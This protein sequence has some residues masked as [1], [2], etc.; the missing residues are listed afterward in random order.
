[1]TNRNYSS[2][3]FRKNTDDAVIVNEHKT[4][5]RE[6]NACKVVFKDKHGKEQEVE[7]SRLIQVFLNNIWENKKSVK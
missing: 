6:A 1:M 3:D 4:V 7:V 5:I 2:H